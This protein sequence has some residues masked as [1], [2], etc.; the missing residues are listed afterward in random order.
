MWKVQAR[1]LRPR[2][3]AIAARQPSRDHIAFLPFDFTLTSSRDSTLFSYAVALKLRRAWR[4]CGGTA[5][6]L[7]VK[8]IKNQIRGNAKISKPNR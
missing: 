4:G 5:P 7:P 8:K 6:C 2:A 1:E 3:D